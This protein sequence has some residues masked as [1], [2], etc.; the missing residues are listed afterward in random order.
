MNKGIWLFLS[1]AAI[2][3]LFICVRY[4]R[5]SL[6]Y[7]PFEAIAALQSELTELKGEYSNVQCCDDSVD[8]EELRKRAVEDL[9]WCRLRLIRSWNMTARRAVM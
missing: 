8:L 9:G 3:A 7:E 2:A 1:I 5:F 6:D 4:F